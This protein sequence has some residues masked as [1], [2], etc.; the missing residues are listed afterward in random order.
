[1]ARADAAL[2]D[3]PLAKGAHAMMLSTAVREYIGFKRD[4]GQASIGTQR[5]YHTHLRALVNY[6]I[7]A[8]GRDSCQAMTTDMVRAFLDHRRQ[9]L[10]P[11]TLRLVSVVVGGFARWGADEDRRFWTTRAVKGLRALKAAQA[12]PRPFDPAERERL[13][14]LPLTGDEATIRALLYFGGLRNA[15]VCALRLRDVTPPHVLPTGE[16]IPG[17]LY[18]FGKGSK[19]RTVDMH[20]ALWAAVEAHLRA[21][22]PATPLTRRLVVRPGNQEWTTRMIQQ[23]ARAWGRAAEVHDVRP[24][25]FRHDFASGLLEAGEDI[26][27]IQTL[28]GHSSL[29]T[30]EVYTKV[31][32]QA[33]ARAVQRRQVYGTDIQPPVTQPVEGA[34][35]VVQRRE[36]T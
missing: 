35:N 24:H 31:V 36:D 1:M 16:T 33:R 26:R 3:G 28:L 19:E 8:T 11:R 34:E 21:V 22:P 4:E 10:N 25:R 14:R 2:F 32:D 20:A 15:E 23:R 13:M 17:R 6:V 30:T 18:V 5:L 9:H 7:H 12:L 27:T 29:A